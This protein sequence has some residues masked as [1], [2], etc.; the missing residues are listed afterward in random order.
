MNET[1]MNERARKMA[2]DELCR[3]NCLCPKL[4]SLGC[5]S[6]CPVFAALHNYH[7]SQDV[8]SLNNMS[9]AEIARIAESGCAQKHFWVG[10][11]KDVELLT[12]E[13]VKLVILGFN[14]DRIARTSNRA[15]ITFGFKGIIDGWYEMNEVWSNEGGWKDSKMR[16]VYMERLYRLLPDA[17][18]AVIKQVEKT[19]TIGGGS[20]E[21]GTTVDKLFLFSESE[22]CG[23]DGD[24][25]ADEGAQYAYFEDDENNRIKR[26]SG[27][28]TGYWWLR[29]PRVDDSYY[30][31]YVYGGGYVDG[32]GADNSNGV[33]LGFCV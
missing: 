10:Q 30:F 9:W 6:S 12:G 14:H 8:D 27:G 22:V 26:R 20:R 3:T 4:K 17:A 33:C 29:S 24:D 2:E 25:V 1:K 15:G 32:D 31:L 18:K 28:S 23:L 21:V 11:E 19:T 5:E 7:V 13:V 16:T